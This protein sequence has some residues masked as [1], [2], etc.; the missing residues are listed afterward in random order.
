MSGW[1]RQRPHLSSPPPKRPRQTP[2]SNREKEEDNKPATKQSSLVV[3][4]GLS[5]GCTVLDLKSRF[6]MFGSISRLR[7]DTA[8]SFGYLTF[9]SHDSA[10][11]AVAAALDPSTGITVGSQKVGVSWAN[12]PLPQWRLGVGATSGK[13]HLLSSSK[14]LRPEIPLSRHG[15]DNKKLSPGAKSTPSKSGPELPFK[16]REIIAYD[17][18]L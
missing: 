4:T 14:L 11:A 1:K 17:D 5:P 13:D 15:R 8:G 2:N 6:Q 7:I 10:Q 12:D 9:R 16:G 3:V 18:L